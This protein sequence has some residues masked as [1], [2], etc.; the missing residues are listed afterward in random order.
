MVEVDHVVPAQHPDRSDGSEEENDSD[1]RD[2]QGSVRGQDLRGAEH[3]V[4]G[5]HEDRQEDDYVQ[6]A[7]GHD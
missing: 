7:L 2:E 5:D 1:T 6:Q 3:A 4:Y